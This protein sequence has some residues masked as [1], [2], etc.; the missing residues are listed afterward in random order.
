MDMIAVSNIMKLV[1]HTEGDTSGKDEKRL[2]NNRIKKKEMN[3]NMT[4]EITIKIGSQNT[5]AVQIKDGNDR[6]LL[7]I[8]LL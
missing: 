4:N 6:H 3:Q 2:R 1:V 7:L 8:I 5:A